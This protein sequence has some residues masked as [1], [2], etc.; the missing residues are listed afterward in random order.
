[1]EKQERTVAVGRQKPYALYVHG[2]GSGARTRTASQ[3]PE[4]IPDYEWIAVEV[5]EDAEEAVGKINRYVGQY[6]PEV[7]MGTSLGGYYIFYAD[8]PDAVKIIC[9]PALNIDEIIRTKIGFG[10][11]K[12]FVR[13]ENKQK[14]FILDEQVCQRFADYRTTHE[15]ILGR[16]NY[17]F[18]GDSDELIGPEGT[19]HNMEVVSDA[20]YRVFVEHDGPHRIQESTLQ[21]VRE[22]V[23]CSADAMQTYEEWKKEQESDEDLGFRLSNLLPKRTGL[24]MMVW[25]EEKALPTAKS[26]SQ[27]CSTYR[28]DRM[29]RMRFTNNTS[30]SLLDSWLPI[31]VEKR[32]PRILVKDYELN[33][34]DKD[35]ILLKKWI[36]RNCDTL[37][38]YWNSKIDTEECITNLVKI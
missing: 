4:Y 20:G 33:I 37:T 6:R 18:F 11:H 29:P 30:D 19:Q 32:N 9:N 2:L 16:A 25:I 3:L 10:E 13:R 7:L 26:R 27:S 23:F 24:S 38:D 15:P 8:A 35:F 17:A 21:L 12:Y 28:S 1:M 5:A 31:S 36:V 14:T 34:S 22:K